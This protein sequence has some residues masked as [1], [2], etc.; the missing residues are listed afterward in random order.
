MRVRCPSSSEDRLAG[1]INGGFKNTGW[2]TGGCTAAFWKLGQEV[3]T[4]SSW[5]MRGQK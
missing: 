2:A 5:E 4:S 1:Q 3:S